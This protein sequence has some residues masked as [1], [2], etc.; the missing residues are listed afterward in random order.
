MDIFF[1]LL[2][3]L[4]T[5][6]VFLLVYGA[7]TLM[8]MGRWDRSWGRWVAILYLAVLLSL[9]LDIDTLWVCLM[10]GFPLPEMK[11][12]QGG[13]RLL[14]LGGCQTVWDLA[15]LVG[16]ALLFVPAGV[17]APL[18][19]KK[20]QWQFA[21]FCGFLLSLAIECVQFVLGRTFDVNDLLMNTVGALF[22]WIAWRI[23]YSMRSKMAAG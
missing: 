11:A 17:L 12:F 10:Y 3:S 14:P 23:G 1:R 4:P 22:G 18:L 19:S 7:V 6:A 16:N 2:W 8:R 20:R 9:T 5:A 21:V 15:M 13:V